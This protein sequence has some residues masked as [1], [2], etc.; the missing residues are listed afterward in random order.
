MES[1]SV[2]NSPEDYDAIV[3]SGT[4]DAGDLRIAVKNGA[5]VSGRPAVAIGFTCY[6]NRDS[7]N[8]L[9]VQTATTLTLF[10]T[11][12]RMLVSYYPEIAQEVGLFTTTDPKIN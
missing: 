4:P 6:P 5:L 1:L 2:T 7:E 11:A 10:L 3:H 9:R 12:A 8:P